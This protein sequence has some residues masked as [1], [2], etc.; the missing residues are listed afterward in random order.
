VLVNL[1]VVG[2]AVRANFVA[3]VRR[4]DASIGMEWM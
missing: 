1:R 2:N 4:A 3:E